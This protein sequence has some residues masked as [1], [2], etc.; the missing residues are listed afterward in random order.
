MV[1]HEIAKLFATMSALRDYDPRREPSQQAGDEEDDPVEQWLVTNHLKNGLETWRSQ[2]LKMRQ[3]AEELPARCWLNHEPDFRNR[4]EEAGQRIKERLEQI[5]LD[6]QEMIRECEMGMQGATLATSLAH[7]KANID[8][9]LSTKKDGSQMKSIALLTM[10]FL[11][12]TFV[13]SMFSMT[14][15]QWIPDN[16]TQ[17]VS[18]YIW[19]YFVATVGLTFMTVGSWYL[20]A[21][22]K[23]APMNGETD[24]EQGHGTSLRKRLS[25]LSTFTTKTFSSQS[26]GILSIKKGTGNREEFSLEDRAVV[27]VNGQK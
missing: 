23:R 7:T 24:L 17:T 4:V 12:A 8:I 15:F 14:F 10:V 9:A 2:L 5:L 11:P 27:P 22:T 20:F 26:T 3:H 25:D 6:Y 13:T 21:N 1:K 19:I 16:S 18:P